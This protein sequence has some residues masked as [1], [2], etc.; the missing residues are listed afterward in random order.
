MSADVTAEEQKP[1]LPQ[2]GEEAWP[3]LA[4]L[5]EYDNTIPLEARTVEVKAI[6]RL[7]REKIVFRTTQRFFASGYLQLPATGTA[8]FPCVLLLHGW[9][10]SEEIWYQ[11]KNDISGGN[12]RKRLLEQGYAVFM[13]DAQCH[14]DRIAVN[15]FAPIN[16]YVNEEMR[17]GQRRKGYFTQRE[18]YTQTVADYHRAID[19]LDTQS[20]ID[21]NRIGLIGYSMGG[22][23]SFMLTAVETRIKAT[24]ACATPS[25]LQPHTLYAPQNYIHAIGD[26]PFFI[27]AGSNDTM[28]PMVYA[29]QLYTLIPSSIKDLKFYDGS[30]KLIPAFV[31]HAVQWIETH[32][33]D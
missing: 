29:R 20:E 18:I 5:Y 8:S 2:I 31:P 1:G 11:D 3:L 13:L 19:Y 6:D 24:V 12:I 25:E 14:G 32:I 23:Q 22:T 26:R 30:H 33:G 28:C 7:R 9:S 15:D 4:R 21:I 27:V 16:H 10:G 17:V